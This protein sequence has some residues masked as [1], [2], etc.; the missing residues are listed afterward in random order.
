MD[1]GTGHVAILGA[2]SFGTAVA[3][4]ATRNGHS[5]VIYCRN[6]EQV[7]SINEMHRNP[8]RL[9]EYELSPLIRATTDFS[10]AVTGAMLMVHCI[11]AQMTPA[12]LSAHAHEIPRD[13]PLVSTAK[14]IVVETME[15][16]SEAIPRVLGAPLPPLAYMSGPSFAKEM[17]LGHPMA[18]VVASDDIE[19]A[20]GVQRV[21]GSTFF[22]LYITTDVVGVEVGGAIKNPLAIGAGMADGLGYGQSTLAALVSRGMG[23]MAKLAAAMGG[24][25]ETLAGLSGVGDLML[26]SF[27]TLSRNRTLGYRMAKDGLT[28]EEAIASLGQVAEGV[29]TARVAAALCKRHGLDLPI[30]GAM[31]E[32]LDGRITPKDALRALM[33]RPAEGEGIALSDVAPS[34]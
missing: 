4:I 7:A 18:L 34:T 1:A 22:R 28:L 19:V 8:R 3:T 17:M 14:G 30:F 2:G 16:M 23:E 32:I 26:T 25:P 27:S 15:L 21:L 6:A 12:F 29:A 24:R 20:R 10:A 5:V 13:V 31:S 33:S 9:S 11:P